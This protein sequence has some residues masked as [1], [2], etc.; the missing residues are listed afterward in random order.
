MLTDAQIVEAC[1]AIW[2]LAYETKRTPEQAL[3]EYERLAKE[4]LKRC[5]T[6]P[7]ETT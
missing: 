7:P 2:R 1:K 6:K 3:W 4:R 5:E